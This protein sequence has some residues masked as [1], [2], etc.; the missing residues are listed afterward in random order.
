MKN[1]A[2]KAVTKTVRE[3]AKEV[4]TDLQCCPNGMVWPVKVLK[5]DSKE[6]ESGRCVNGS[7]GKLCFSLK[8]RG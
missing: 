3:K 2:R 6:V 7:D 5:C 4:L 1:K 8:E